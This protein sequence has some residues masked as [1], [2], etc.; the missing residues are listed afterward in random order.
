MFQNFEPPEAAADRGER[1][2]GLRAALG[3]A[4]VDAIIVPR[5]DAHQGETVPASEERLAWLT[6]FTGSAGTAIV[7]A[8]RAALFV[9]GRYTL[10][11]AAQAD[12]AAIE[13]VPTRDRSPEDWA[14]EVLGRDGRLGYD[15]WLHAK[16][17]IDRYEERLPGRLVALDT[18][19]IDA[20][21]T[22]RPP[23]PMGAVTIH[24]ETLAG[25]SA[26]E[27]RTRL[28]AELAKAGADA[29]VLTLPDSIAWLL[30]IRGGDL[31][32]VP[33][34]L[35][36]AILMA[37]GR[38]RLFMEPDKL[39]G[40]VRAHLGEAVS[41]E[42]PDALGAALDGLGEKT[43]R[44]DRRSCALWIA[45]R[46]EAAGAT[47]DWGA[48][49]CILPKARK[50]PTELAGMR[51][52]HLRDGAAMARFLHW[53][54]GEAEAG[55]SIGEIALAERLEAFRAETGALLDIAF[56]TISG[57]GPNAA[58]PHYRVNRA[59]ERMLEPGEV[60]LVD[61][62][63]QYA[64]GTTDITRTVA[65][66]PPVAAAVKPFTLVLKGMIAICRARWPKGLA[67]RDLDPLARAALWRAGLDYDHGTGHGVGA[68][69]NV[70]EG[71]AS[72][73]RRSGDVALEPGM[74][75]SNEPGYYREGA[76]G[77]RLE[78]LCAVTEP[79][80][81]AGGERQ[82]LGMETLTLCPFDRAMI[83]PGLLDAEEIAWLDAYHARVRAALEPLLPEDAARWLAE[84]TRPLG[85][86]RG[87]T[88]GD[89]P[90]TH[91][92]TLAPAMGVHVVRSGD[93]VIA[94]TQNALL[95]TEPG[96]DPVIYFP[97]ADVG[98][99][100][101]DKSETVTTC[102]LKGEATHY[103]YAGVGQTIEDAAWS[104]E[105]PVPGAEAIAG[106]VAFYPDKLAVE[107]L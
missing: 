5:A 67:G 104:Y 101:L 56:D 25:E 65:Y 78:V 69:L 95:L 30:N 44:L 51:A 107:R 3:E 77:I 89:L 32:H 105:S 50:N 103:S 26:A 61:S 53:L 99:E 6:G 46:L 102:P 86:D 62:G 1:L 23:V 22:G 39:D 18:N 85:R 10:Q 33:V 54:A 91:A 55:R 76:F 49:P 70:H 57:S 97:R 38:V 40:P 87:P 64:D 98:M 92:F 93:A 100:F 59:K 16:A 28:G 11:A 60:Y 42:A 66:G 4:G 94:E 2:A 34:A 12:T 29:A 90:M 43:I 41:L 15:P 80:V 74:I 68:Y 106:Y 96:H 36:F 20:L 82:M 52:A 27:K 47:I 71:P 8:D 24:P 21:W 13:V 72:I 75:L 88:E 83:D 14:A 81:P 37:D 31:S 79:S 84:A 63:G 19:P 58:L 45:R 9:D 17:E 7:T 48:D 35:G 73:S